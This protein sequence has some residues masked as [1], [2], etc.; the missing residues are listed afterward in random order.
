MSRFCPGVLRITTRLASA[1]S[2]HA[3]TAWPE[4]PSGQ[5]Q[6]E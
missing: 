4:R 6:K 3:K 2:S 5:L 1:R